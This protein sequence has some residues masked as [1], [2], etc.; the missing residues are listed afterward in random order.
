MTNQT[1]KILTDRFSF[2]TPQDRIK[3]YQELFNTDKGQRV[4]SDLMSLVGFYDHQPSNNPNEAIYREGVRSGTLR[5]L[6]ILS[7]KDIE[8]LETQSN[9]AN[10]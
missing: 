8:K 4:L 2:Q 10:Y 1:L 7:V 6:D 9:I 3:A 5:I